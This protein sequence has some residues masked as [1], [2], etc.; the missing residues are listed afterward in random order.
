MA[1]T[2][3]IAPLFLR[4]ALA[5]TFLWAGF[6]KILETFPVKGQDAATL[7]NWHVLSVAP[8]PAAPPRPT[9]APSAPPEPPAKK[10]A[11]VDHGGGPS[12][13]ALGVMLLV[14]NSP[15]PLPAAPSTTLPAPTIPAAAITPPTTTTAL[16]VVATEVF[17]TAA[18]FPDEIRVSRV[19]KIALLVE[20]AANPGVS[21][22]G[23]LKMPIWPDQLAQAR[24]PVYFAWA[25]TVTE[26]VAGLFILVGLLTRFSAISLAFTMLVAIW[27]TEIGPAIQAG[28][29][30]LGFLPSHAAYAADAAGKPLYATLLWQV[31]LLC[32]AIALALTGPGSLSFDRALFPPRIAPRRIAADVE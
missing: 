7:A 2:S 19:Y 32:S 24:A 4:A 25:A 28:D 27:L 22:D 23:A 31:S 14:Q 9:Q 5:V 6:G 1:T 21:I 17:R 20:E 26:L 15:K 29:A 10:S 8:P 16:S 12:P 3:S 18:D 11:L 13:S 30:F